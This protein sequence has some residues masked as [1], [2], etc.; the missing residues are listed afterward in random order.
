MSDIVIR[1]RPAPD[2][3]IAVPS[4]PRPCGPVSQAVVTL[5]REP[6]TAT[7]AER[8]V[9]AAFHPHLDPLTDR[10][11]QLGLWC[12][13]ELHLDGFPGTDPALEWSPALLAARAVLE[14]PFEAALR[15]L[16]G[17]LSPDDPIEE[18]R[19][20][21]GSGRPPRLARFLGRDATADQFRD[22][23][24]QRAVYHLRESDP[25]SFVL[26]RVHGRAKAALAELQYDEYGAG[27]PD[28]LHATLYARALA[29]LD[30]PTGV[31]A[32]VDTAE[33]TILTTVNVMALFGLHRRLRGAALGHL[34]AF[35]ATSSIPCRLIALGAHRLGFPAAVAT[36]Y[37][38][39]VEADAV[40]EQ[41]AIHDICGGLLE[42]SPELAGDVVFGAAAC[43]AVD[44]LTA[45]AL[46][47]RWERAA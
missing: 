26:P 47:A 39:H 25:Q 2:H 42:S 31:A 9:R 15:R 27:R 7:Q 28:R 41:V 12:L 46:L 34:A 45:T 23:L 10:D 43:L 29:S 3:Q 37:E 35:E 6:A 32:Y 14:E 11:F 24:A 36:Y 30:L 8:R 33:A 18:V 19:R 1:P 44:E 13:Y 22:Y 17:P 20:L 4:L 5:L 16:V 38:E 40:H 21:T